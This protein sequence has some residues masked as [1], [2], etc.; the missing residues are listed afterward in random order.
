MH[1]LKPE[2]IITVPGDTLYTRLGGEAGLSRLIKWFYAKVRFDPL[3]EPIF[4]AH[5]EVW[6]EH[7]LVLVQFW[8]RMTGGPSTWAGGMGRHFF[9]ELQPEHFVA[10]LRVWDE[11]CTELLPEPERGEM[12]QLAHSIAQDLQGMMQRAGAIRESR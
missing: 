7:L 9:L 5:V 6:S 4:R 3:L 8:A 2:P 10:W 1:L 12:I 11:N